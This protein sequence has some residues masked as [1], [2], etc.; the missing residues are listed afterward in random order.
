MK[1]INIIWQDIRSG[2]NLDVYIA[3]IIALTV[4]ILGL[5]GQ[6]DQVIIST[7]ILATLAL[8]ANG[9][10]INRRENE[11]I[12]KALLSIGS[13]G[14]LAEKF[15]TREYDRMRVR[16]LLEKS[17][18]AFFWGPYLNT[19]IIILKDIIKER[20]RDK[21]DPIVKTQKVKFKVRILSNFLRLVMV[22]YPI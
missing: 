10:L 22:S 3:I 16:K 2:K 9:L 18:T 20:L 1:I 19:H 11:D 21:V 8:V 17:H 14:S 6:V 13:D 15:L 7:A 12:Q 4:S 5:I